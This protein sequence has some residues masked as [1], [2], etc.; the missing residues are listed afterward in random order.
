MRQRERP[1]DLLASRRAVGLEQRPD[2]RVVGDQAARGAQ[3]ADPVRDGGVAWRQPRGERAEV[4]RGVVT[5][6]AGELGG[7]PLEVGGAS[8]AEPVL[9]P[10][11]GIELHHRDGARLVRRHALREVHAGAQGVVAQHDAEWIAGDPS[12]EGGALPEPGEAERDVVRAAARAGQP[13]IVVAELDEVD[14]RLADHRNRR[15]SRHRADATRASDP[16]ARHP[17]AER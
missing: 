3:L 14:Q 12:D 4:H 17:L 9:R 7:G 13:R 6:H 5:W 1:L 11:C 15:R 16:L 2:V 10:A 8:D